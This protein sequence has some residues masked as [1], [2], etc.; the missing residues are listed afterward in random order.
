ML[1]EDEDMVNGVDDAEG[2]GPRRRS[3]SAGANSRRVSS[4][5]Q[6]SSSTAAPSGGLGGEKA[7]RALSTYT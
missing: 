1:D 5:G 7:R 2:P 6:R 4:V 3:S